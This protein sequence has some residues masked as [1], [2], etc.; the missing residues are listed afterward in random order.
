MGV[1]TSDVARDRAI[2]EAIVDQETIAAISGEGGFTY[3][4]EAEMRQRIDTIFRDLRGGTNLGAANVQADPSD[5]TTG[6]PVPAPVTE[7]ISAAVTAPL[8]AV[9]DALS[10]LSDR[11]GVVATYVLVGLGLYALISVS[12]TVRA[13]RGR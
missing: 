10:A 13:F 2:A 11:V 6:Q 3:Q 4:N 5:V 1:P 9:K 8:E 7:R 12:G